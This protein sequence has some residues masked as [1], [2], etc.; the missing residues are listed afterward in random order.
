MDV[1]VVGD[2]SF[3]ALREELTAAGARVSIHASAAEM[4]ASLHPAVVVDARSAPVDLRIDD[5]CRRDALNLPRSKD[6]SRE[7]NATPAFMAVP[8]REIRGAKFVGMYGRLQS[9]YS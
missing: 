9:V 5:N 8:E 6:R 7:H 2:P 4:P 3:G 1:V